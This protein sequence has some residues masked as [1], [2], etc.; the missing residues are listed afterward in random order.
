MDAQRPELAAA[1]ASGEPVFFTGDFNEPSHLDWTEAAAAAG[2]IPLAVD[3]PLSHVFIDDLGMIDGYHQDR[4]QDGEDEV[5][6]WGYT[7]TSDG[8]A[9]YDDDRIDFVYYA[10]E[11]VEVVDSIL[12]GEANG[13][14]VRGS[15]D[16]DIKAWW[17]S[18]Y[19]TV[20]DHRA[21]AVR[22]ELPDPED[23]DTPDT[24]TPDDTGTMVDTGEP[25]DTGSTPGDT[26]SDVPSSPNPD[27]ADSDD[28]STCGCG[29]GTGTGP[30]SLA[31]LAAAAW[32]RREAATD[33][34]KEP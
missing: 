25:T 18:D 29:G 24:G 4:V 5:S 17:D 13:S 31:L 26:G 32:R 33:D 9:S 34:R 1:L 6:R 16:V 10:G 7:W 23:T 21:V 19:Y 27:D 30:F 2:Y 15:E 28:I 8:A 12:V 20:S 22:F 14:G 3:A 11:R